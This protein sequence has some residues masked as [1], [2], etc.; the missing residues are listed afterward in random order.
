VEA[1]ETPSKYGQ[2]GWHR[3]QGRK[4]KAVDGTVHFWS[5]GGPICGGRGG[6]LSVNSDKVN[7]VFC[8]RTK[9]WKRARERKMAHELAVR[10]TGE[11]VDAS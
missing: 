3:K 2:S 8:K 5:S 11:T 1:G 4:K 7:R 9:E 10:S 6:F